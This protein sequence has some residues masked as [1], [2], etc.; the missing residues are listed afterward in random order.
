MKEELLKNIGN[1][2]CDHINPRDQH[3]NEAAYWTM[4]DL[5]QMVENT[6]DEVIL[7]KCRSIFNRFKFYY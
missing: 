4:L 2:M 5:L 7:S 1:W 3:I 6:E